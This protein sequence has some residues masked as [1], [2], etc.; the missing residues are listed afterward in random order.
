[1][2][3]RYTKQSTPY[4]IMYVRIT[5]RMLEFKAIFKNK[6]SEIYTNP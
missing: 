5:I 3:K 2:S 4:D 6:K 1:M